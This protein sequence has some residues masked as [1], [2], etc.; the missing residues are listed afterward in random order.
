MS[1]VARRWLEEQ[2]F[3]KERAGRPDCRRSYHPQNLLHGLSVAKRL[4]ASREESTQWMSIVQY[5]KVVSR[6]FGLRSFYFTKFGTVISTFRDRSRRIGMRSPGWWVGFLRSN[7][8]TFRISRNHS[9]DV[10]A[11]GLFCAS[12]ERCTATRFVLLRCTGLPDIP[13]LRSQTAEWYFVMRHSVCVLLKDKVF[14][15]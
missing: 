12:Q 5:S 7:V 11:C 2:Y 14:V 9:R 6:C 4:S 13:A 1:D 3:V 15:F 8:M 10:S